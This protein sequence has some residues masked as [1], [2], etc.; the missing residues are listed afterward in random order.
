MYVL[1]YTE[2]IIDMYLHKPDQINKIV[3]SSSLFFTDITPKFIRS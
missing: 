1:A 2:A 3:D